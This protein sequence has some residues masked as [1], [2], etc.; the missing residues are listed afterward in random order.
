VYWQIVKQDQHFAADPFFT[1]YNPAVDESD[2]AHRDR[3]NYAD[4]LPQF[5]SF[6]P[7]D[8]V[9]LK[10]RVDRISEIEFT[11]PPI[12]RVSRYP[13]VESVQIIAYHRLIRFRDLVDV[14]IGDDNR[15]WNV[16]RNP[17]WARDFMDFQLTEE[18]TLG[19]QFTL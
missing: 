18:A 8:A 4:H 1:E 6:R 10:A 17:T 16:H 15:F 13:D 12:P 14:I 7:L 3:G 11:S 5:P 19:S 9:A 2:V